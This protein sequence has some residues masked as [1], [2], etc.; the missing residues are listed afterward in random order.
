M[1]KKKEI[2]GSIFHSLRVFS[3]SKVAGVITLVPK[4]SQFSD[5]IRGFSDGIYEFADRI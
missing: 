2:N 5:G 3:Y 1:M 4:T